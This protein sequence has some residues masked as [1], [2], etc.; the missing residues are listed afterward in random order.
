[1]KNHACLEIVLATY[2][3]Q[4]FIADQL[5]SLQ[6]CIGYCDYVQRVLVVDDA[7]MDNTASIVKRISQNDPRIVWV[8][9]T[10]GRLGVAANFHRGLE[11]TQAQY[12]MLCDQDDIWNT[13]K[14][15]LQLELCLEHENRQGTD[16]PLLVFSDLQVVDETLNLLSTSFFSYQD[17]SPEWSEKFRNLLIQNVAPGCTLMLNRTLVEKALPFPPQVVMHDWWLMLVAS[18]FGQ[19]MWLDQPLVQY[20]QHD[21]NQVGAKHINWNWLL[22]LGMRR[23]TATVNMKNIGRQALAFSHRHGN[24]PDLRLDKHDHIVLNQIGQLS[25]SSLSQRLYNFLRGNF[26]KNNILRNLG[27]LLVLI[28][29]PSDR[30]DV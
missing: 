14:I 23:Q 8:P 13:D 4:S 11:L 21:R 10:D 25:A 22:S 1:V 16:Q 30:D 15:K 5:L 17:L 9:A 7:S 18:A 27:L 20:R 24:D 6:R 28:L 3:G 29:W 19:I 2:N 12:V 26:R